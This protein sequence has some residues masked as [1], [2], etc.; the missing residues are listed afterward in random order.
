MLSLR[1]F[2][3]VVLQSLYI[4]TQSVLL[5]MHGPGTAFGLP[6]SYCQLETLKISLIKLFNNI[7]EPFLFKCSLPYLNIEI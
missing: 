2:F 3:S 5:N 1:I 4:L 6:P 7:S